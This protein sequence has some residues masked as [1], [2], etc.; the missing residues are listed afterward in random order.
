MFRGGCSRAG[1]VHR[2]H[3]RLAQFTPEA[4]VEKVS[5]MKL[6]ERLTHLITIFDNPALDSSKNRADGDDLL[7]DAYEYLMRH[8]A[9]ESGKSRGQFLTPSEVPYS[10]NRHLFG[11]QCSSGTLPIRIFSIRCRSISAISKR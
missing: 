1:I 6:V 4:E 8:F 10:L 5:R 11:A 2:R 3:L 9:T 7:D